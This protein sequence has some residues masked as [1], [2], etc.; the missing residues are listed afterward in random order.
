MSTELQIIAVIESIA[1]HYPDWKI[2][3]TDNPV[4]CRREYNNPVN[5]RHWDAISET[6][7]RKIEMYFIYKGMQSDSSGGFYPHYVYIFI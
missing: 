4:K 2:G 5:W 6:Y 7:A 1:E 3:I